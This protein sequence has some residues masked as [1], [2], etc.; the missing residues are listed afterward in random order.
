MSA[1]LLSIASTIL[2]T[3]P[4]T[5]PRDHVAHESGKIALARALLSLPTIVERWREQAAE[6]RGRGDAARAEGIEKCAKEIE[7]VIGN[8]ERREGAPRSERR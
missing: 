7:A 6:M 1:R 4:L 2:G 5:L 8:R 3:R